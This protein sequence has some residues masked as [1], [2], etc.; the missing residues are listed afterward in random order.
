MGSQGGPV[1]RG[2]DPRDNQEESC[3]ADQGKFRVVVVDDDP[4]ILQAFDSALNRLGYR[5]TSF[6][7]SLE[8]LKTFQEHPSDYDLL[9]TDQKMPE[10]EGD[11][12]AEEVL[13]MRPEFP[14]ILCTGFANTISDAEAKAKGI[15]GFLLKPFSLDM[16]AKT[17]AS[18]LCKGISQPSRAN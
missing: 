2:R 11:K 8:A 15:R 16:L 10:L 14:I 13:R 4:I 18:I 9:L 6:E 12:L 5:V 17:V 3:I 7:R 1:T